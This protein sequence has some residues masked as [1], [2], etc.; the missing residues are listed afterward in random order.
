MVKTK[1]PFP[2]ILAILTESLEALSSLLN[3]LGL[4]AGFELVGVVSPV[5]AVLAQ[6]ARVVGQVQVTAL[7]RQLR[8]SV[9]VVARVTHELGAMLS[10][11]VVTA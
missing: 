1:I 4:L 3:R 9:R 2:S 5:V 8:V 10:K 6:A 7:G 11:I